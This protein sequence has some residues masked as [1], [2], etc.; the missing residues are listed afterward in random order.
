MIPTQ[1]KKEME[2]DE[3][4]KRCALH[5]FTCSESVEW[6]HVFQYGGSSIQEKWAIVPACKLHHDMVKTSNE[7]R[8]SF[9]RI[10][11]SRA[12]KEDLEKYPNKDWAQLKEYLN[13]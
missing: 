11:L 6:H 12:T 5:L 4:Y 1:I 13:I 10:A 2:D 7:V 8:E 9:E 3:F